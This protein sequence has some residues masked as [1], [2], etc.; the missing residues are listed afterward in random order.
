MSPIKPAIVVVSYNRPYSLKRLLK[1]LE[2]A[3]YPSADIPLIISIDRGANNMNVFAVAQSFN[4][5]HGDKIVKYQNENLGL[6]RHIIKC[7][8]LSY[9]YESVIIL[10]DDI[11]VSVE[12]YNYTIQAMSFAKNLAYIGGISLYNHQFSLSAL[13]SFSP[14]EDGYDNWY[15]QYAS[16]WGQAWTKEQWTN[17]F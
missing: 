10:E 8:S 17:P 6:R 9:D 3:I 13:S 16:S 14:L 4:W 5:G 11:F 2:A 1:S 15:F 12:F 7:A